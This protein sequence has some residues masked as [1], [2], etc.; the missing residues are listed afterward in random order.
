MEANK[1]P[2]ALSQFE[3]DL[4]SHGSDKLQIDSVGEEAADANMTSRFSPSVTYAC[5]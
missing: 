5:S 1:Y 3:L 2:F 4:P